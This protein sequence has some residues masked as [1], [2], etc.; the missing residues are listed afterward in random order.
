MPK[1]RMWHSWLEMEMLF[2]MWKAICSM[3]CCKELKNAKTLLAIHLSGQLAH[4]WSMLLLT[5]S[6]GS[7]RKLFKL[8]ETTLFSL[9]VETSMPIHLVWVGMIEWTLSKIPKGTVSFSPPLEP[10]PGNGSTLGNTQSNLISHFTLIR[11]PLEGSSPLMFH[12]QFQLSHLRDT[13][14]LSVV[15]LFYSSHLLTGKKLMVATLLFHS[16]T[17]KTTWNLLWWPRELELLRKVQWHMFTWLMMLEQESKISHR[18]LETY[19]AMLKS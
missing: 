2:M 5:G 18:S 12:T 8:E 4:N 16:L 14:R 1:R 17:L 9:Q 3:K 15:I 7:M 11:I 10:W 19:L 13:T 6:N